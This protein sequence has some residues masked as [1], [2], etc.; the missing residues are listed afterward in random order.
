[1]SSLLNPIQSPTDFT[2]NVH[3]QT[4]LLS[5]PGLLADMTAFATRRPPPNAVTD[6]ASDAT[7]PRSALYLEIQAKAGYYTHDKPRM[8]SPDP[9][10]VEISTH[11]LQ[12][13]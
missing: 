9:V 5:Q 1:M 8:E 2:L 10:K 3:T 13:P 12:A 6:V 7:A 4:Q 11:I